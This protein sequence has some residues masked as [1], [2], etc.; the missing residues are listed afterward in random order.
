MIKIIAVDDNKEYLESLK[1]IFKKSQYDKYQL[2]QCI[3]EMKDEYNIEYMLAQ[4]EKIA[5]DVVLMD[6]SF[7][8]QDKPHDFGIELVRR[9]LMKFPAQK[10]IMLVGD[11]N[12]D[13]LV[14]W[15]KIRRSFEVGAM[16]YLRK[17]DIA[18]WTEGIDE[19]VNGDTYVTPDTLKTIVDGIRNRNKIDRLQKPYKLSNRQ[20]EVLSHLSKDKTLQQVADS[21]YGT[22]ERPIT[23]HTVNFHMRNI[24]ALFNANTLHGV[25]AKAIRERLID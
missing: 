13:D 18:S 1:Q 10:I 20:L 25:I 15:G 7:T 11:D 17:G 19:T 5:P 6:F 4:V 24:R 3:S 2:V 21:I 23:I 9:I 14:R 8:L 22:K 16:A 12:D